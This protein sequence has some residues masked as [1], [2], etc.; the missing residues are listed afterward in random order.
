MY[1]EI[2]V[3]FCS[4][5]P[6]IVNNTTL[7]SLNHDK[8]LLKAVIFHES[9]GFTWDMLSWHNLQGCL[10]VDPLDMPRT[11]YRASEEKRSDYPTLPYHSHPHIIICTSFISSID[12]NVIIV[13]QRHLKDHLCWKV[14]AASR[15][16]P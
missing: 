7:L 3:L 16:N 6:K 14:T 9:S 2:Q 15:R 11:P 8:L 13:L 5:D 1:T 10:G 12:Y 4:P